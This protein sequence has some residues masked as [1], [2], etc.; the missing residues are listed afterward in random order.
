MKR[1]LR[2]IIPEVSE[3]LGA[4][5][6]VPDPTTHYRWQSAK[7]RYAIG[8][9]RNIFSDRNT[10]KKLRVKSNEAFVG[11]LM[12]PI[13]S[14]GVSVK[15]TIGH[16]LPNPI[17]G[18]VTAIAAKGKEIGRRQEGDK[19]GADRMKKL[20]REALS[21]RKIPKFRPRIRG[22]SYD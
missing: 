22:S 18:G 15:R 10:R 17:R 6:K 13:M 5:Y 2:Q 7:D 9:I 19:I 14:I 20:G 3:T 16:T 11:S 1:P 21:G 4:N 12:S 8:M